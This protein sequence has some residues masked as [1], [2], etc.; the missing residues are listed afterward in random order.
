MRSDIMKFYNEEIDRRHRGEKQEHEPKPY[1]MDN[2]TQ[3]G[4]WA[5]LCSSCKCV[6]CHTA[7]IKIERDQARREGNALY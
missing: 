2:C 1:T 7:F 3:C 5:R 4:R 6:T